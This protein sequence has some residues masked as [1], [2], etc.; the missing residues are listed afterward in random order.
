[1]GHALVGD[2]ILPR[3]RCRTCK[4]ELNRKYAAT[5]TRKE[6]VRAYSRT[7]GR[8]RKLE[9]L[10]LFGGK[11]IDCGYDKHPAALDFDHLDPATKVFQ[12][13]RASQRK[14]WEEL[15]LEAAKCVIRCACCHRIRTYMQ[16]SPDAQVA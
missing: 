10:K 1:M 9:L 7:R 14:A 16:N 3:G 11:C 15:V 6:R 12:I 13:G 2:N 4:N 5:E 8:L